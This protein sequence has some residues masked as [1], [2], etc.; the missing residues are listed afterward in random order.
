MTRDIA[1]AVRDAFVR[2]LVDAHDVLSDGAV[3]KSLTEPVYA[4][5]VDSQVFQQLALRMLWSRKTKNDMDIG[6]RCVWLM[7]RP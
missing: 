1:V 2:G 5:I 3:D 4:Q 7:H 6:R